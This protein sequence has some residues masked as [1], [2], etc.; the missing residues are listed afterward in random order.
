MANDVLRTPE[1]LKVYRA[2]RQKLGDSLAKVDLTK[3]PF[4]RAWKYWV[5]VE[6]EFPYDKIAKKHDL[7]VATRHFVHDAELDI[8]EREELFAIKAEFAESK[9]YDSL[10]ENLSHNR[11][12]P[13]QYHLHCIKFHH[14][15]PIEELS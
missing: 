13:W 4:I 9:E 2:R 5:L 10:L 11:T 15:T 7:L 1:T 12:V 3:L 8:L 14:I 6:N